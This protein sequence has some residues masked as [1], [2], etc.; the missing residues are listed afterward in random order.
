MRPVSRNLLND[1]TYDIEFQGYLTNHVKHAVIAL[2]RLEASSTRVREYWDSYTHLTPYRIPLETVP[3]PWDDVR[4]VTTT[5]WKEWRGQKRDWQAQVV[6]LENELVSRYD[7][8]THKLVADYAPDV[9]NGWVGALTHTIIHLGWALDAAS[10]SWMVL[11][12]LAYLNFAHVGL[13]DSMLQWNAHDD[14]T[15]MDSLMRV[16]TVWQEKD[17]GETWIHKA[18]TSYDETFHPELVPAGFQWE[19]AKVLDQPHAVATELPTWI[20]ETSPT[21]LWESLYRA[22]VY[23]FLATRD[24][25]GNGNFIV[26]HLLTSLWGL[27]QTLIVIDDDEVTCTAI[28]HYYAGLVCLLSTAAKGFPSAVALAT[29]QTSFPTTAVDAVDT[30]WTDTV[31]VGIAQEEEHNIKLVYVM[32]ELWNRYGRWNGFSEAAKSFTLTPNIGPTEDK[33]N[34]FTA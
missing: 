15:P 33:G 22:A 23:L 30:D 31:K 27:E 26:L 3:Q 9:L 32:R 13:D 11:E 12:G 7:G 16:A 18:K 21:K 8:D 34:A 17:L 14:P 5:Q 19:A 10:S 6:F 1:R 24:D 4:P 29:V 20:T 2:E 28:A 25:R